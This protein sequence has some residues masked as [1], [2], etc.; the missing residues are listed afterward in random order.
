MNPLLIQ[1]IVGP[2]PYLSEVA[3]EFALTRTFR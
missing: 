2:P 1:R 3:L